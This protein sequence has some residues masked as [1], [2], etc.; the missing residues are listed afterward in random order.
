MCVCMRG[1]Q[2]NA[3][4]QLQYV[5]SHH[6]LIHAQNPLNCMLHL[7]LSPPYFCLEETYVNYVCVFV[8]VCVCDRERERE[9]EQTGDWNVLVMNLKLSLPSECG[10]S[11]F[12]GFS[13]CCTMFLISC[14]VDVIRRLVRFLFLHLPKTAGSGKRL[15]VNMKSF[16]FTYL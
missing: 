13:F 5:S 2:K 11:L 14:C 1:G 8:C 3:N 7:S 9:W 16:K 12:D 10:R 15:T 4:C 6:W